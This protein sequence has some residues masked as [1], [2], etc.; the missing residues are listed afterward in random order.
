MVQGEVRLEIGPSLFSAGLALTGFTIIHEHA[1]CK[2]EL[3]GSRD[4]LV[5]G[6][7]SIAG[8]GIF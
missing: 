4:N 2:E 6:K 5:G 3:K 8:D 7:G 1:G